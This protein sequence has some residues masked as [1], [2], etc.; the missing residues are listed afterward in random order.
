MKRIKNYK[1][2]LESKEVAKPKHYVTNHMDEVDMDR[3]SKQNEGWIGDALKSASGAFKNFLTNIG[4][5][6]KNLVNDF[7]KGMKIEDVKNKISQTMD[8]SLKSATDAINK[9]KNEQEI[10]N[11]KDS[12]TKE[13]DTKISEFGK[14][15]SKIKESKIYEGVAQDALIGANVIFG[16][17]K[18][19]YQKRKIEFD[20]Q[21]AAAK[22]L[23]G[24]KASAIKSLKSIVDDFKN[25]IKD[26]NAINEL[27]KKY[28][29]ANKI[30]DT[31][32]SDGI[33][34]DWGDVE[35]EFAKLK[36]N[37]KESEFYKISKS[38]SKK[39]LVGDLFK[40]SGV[41]K[42]GSSSTFTDVTRDDKI[43]QQEYKTGN[44][45]KILV[46]GKEANEYT[47]SGVSESD[48]DKQLSDSLGKIKSDKDKMSKVLNFVK[49]IE[50][51]NKM[52]QV[53]KILST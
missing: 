35:I 31:G 3:L 5:P 23:N 40:A 15:I 25:Q 13:I 4:A 28:K 11:I 7:R 9:S 14:E 33:T 43:I 32:T 42:K 27:I 21:F 38:N 51:D 16:M 39:I 26:D 36:I 37:E 18:D 17:F 29:T 46:A 10:N 34:F 12:F 52:N 20:K 45:E 6:F 47:F 2:F 44:L 8:I 49:N 22:D 19:A 50:D 30:L 24:K 41:A 53:S 48:Q 1:H